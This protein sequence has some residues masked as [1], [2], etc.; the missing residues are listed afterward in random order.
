[1]REKTETQ[2]IRMKKGRER[3]LKRRQEKKDLEP[4]TGYGTILE[5]FDE[6]ETQT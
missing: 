1:M 4:Y 3:C 6:K 5:D 2:K